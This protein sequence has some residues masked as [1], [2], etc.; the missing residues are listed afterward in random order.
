M[1]VPVG[2]EPTG[3]HNN[4]LT[5]FFASDANTFMSADVAAVPKSGDRGVVIPPANLARNRGTTSMRLFVLFTR[6]FGDALQEWTELR[7]SS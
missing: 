3:I 5:D 2:G 7:D 1:L 4:N 6:T